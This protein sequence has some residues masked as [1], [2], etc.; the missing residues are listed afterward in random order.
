M[1]VKVSDTTHTNTAPV[2]VPVRRSGKTR[3]TLQTRVA[4]QDLEL[5]MEWLGLKARHPI[6]SSA[7][8][9]KTGCE[10]ESECECVSLLRA[11]ARDGW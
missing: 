1:T 8:P 6:E 7:C 9:S 5:R 2:P 11:L 3:Q 10:S 4:L